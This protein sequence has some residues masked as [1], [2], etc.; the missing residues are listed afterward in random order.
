MFGTVRAV[1]QSF[2]T[3]HSLLGNQNL[4]T[5]AKAVAARRAKHIVPRY[6]KVFFTFFGK[7]A[8]AFLKK[9]RPSPAL[10][11]RWVAEHSN[12]ASAEMGY[13]SNL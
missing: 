2:W 9:I 8:L 6:D 10:R 1:R 3:D 13:G 4:Q 12:V 11:S 5:V 7:N